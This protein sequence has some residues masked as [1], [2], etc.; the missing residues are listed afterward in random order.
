V[1]LDRPPVGELLLG[2]R[3]DPLRRGDP[4]VDE[5]NFVSQALLGAGVIQRAAVI[6]CAKASMSRREKL[7][8]CRTR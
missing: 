8:D 2:E 6:S 7:S 3:E 5:L 4:L 1:C